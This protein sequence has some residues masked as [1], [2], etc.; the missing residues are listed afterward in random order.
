MGERGIT[1]NAVAPG[2]IDTD[3]SAWLRSEAGEQTARQIQ[4]IKRVG[5]AQDVADVVAFLASPD[6]RWITGQVI[7]VSGG[8]KL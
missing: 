8:T 2:A 7:D 4:A 3:M 1:V 6:A 5:K